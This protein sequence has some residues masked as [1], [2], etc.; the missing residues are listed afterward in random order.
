MTDDQRSSLFVKRRRHLRL[1]SRFSIEEWPSIR[2]TAADV[3]PWERVMS[4]LREPG[5]SGDC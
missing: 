3:L 2:V 1:S 4:I 5:Y